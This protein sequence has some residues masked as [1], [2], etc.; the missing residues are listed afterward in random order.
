MGW[1]TLFNGR[2]NSVQWGR[3]TLFNG[4]GELCS[5]GGGT[6][7]NGELNFC[8]ACQLAMCPHFWDEKIS[9]QLLAHVEVM[10]IQGNLV[11]SL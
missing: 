5:M 11:K 1:G 9:S 4:G 7:F 2:G 3:G 10:K 8:P 6:V